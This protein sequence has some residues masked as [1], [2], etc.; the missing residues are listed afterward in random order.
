M[1]ER[2][3]VW[4]CDVAPFGERTLNRGC[5][6]HD[7]HARSNEAEVGSRAHQAMHAVGNGAPPDSAPKDPG[8]PAWGPYCRQWR[9]PV[10]RMHH[11]TP[12]PGCPLCAPSPVKPT[13]D[14][15]PSCV[16]LR[17]TGTEVKAMHAGGCPHAPKVGPDFYG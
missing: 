4:T 5:G 6:Q 14:C 12:L 3:W 13:P 2:P 17:Y 9:V 11:G 7:H 1:L 8:D 10:V 15:T 16:V